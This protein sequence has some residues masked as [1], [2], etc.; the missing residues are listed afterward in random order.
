MRFDPGPSP[1][2]RLRRELGLFIPELAR[3]SKLPERVVLKI[4][5]GK[6]V[7]TRRV[8]RVYKCLAELIAASTPGRSNDLLLERLLD[9]YFRWRERLWKLLELEVAERL[10]RVRMSGGFK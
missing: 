4:E 5:Q 10:A 2:E 7:S 8:C 9:E 6:P 1:L 3:M